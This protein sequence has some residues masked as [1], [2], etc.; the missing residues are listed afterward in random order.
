[1]TT[2]TTGDTSADRVRQRA[3]RGIGKSATA[4]SRTRL[5]APPRQRRPAM[6]ALAVLLIVG[7]AL[8]AGLLAVRMDSREPM[9]TV[10][11][12]LPAGTQITEADLG[13]AQVAAEGLD[14]VPAEQVDQV[15]GTYT[16]SRVLEGQLLDR[17]VLTTEGPLTDGQH[18]IVS[19]VLNP[20]LAPES[21]RDGD[22]VMVVRAAPESSNEAGRAITEAYVMER[23]AASRDDFGGGTAGEL[24]LLVPAAAAQAVVDAAGNNRAGI[25]VLSRDNALDDLSLS[26]AAD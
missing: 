13:Q 25:A 20:G 9:V 6:A 14:L 24:T 10:T 26:V 18:A 5:P 8:L 17:R 11:R 22:V 15:I 7:G 1:M 3:A 12:D 2:Q 23:S 19:V 4:A 21:V 16:S